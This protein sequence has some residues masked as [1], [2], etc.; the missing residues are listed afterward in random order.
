MLDEHGSLD[1]EKPGLSL[2]EVRTIRNHATQRA[3]N[4]IFG[5]YRSDTYIMTELAKEDGMS[6][7]SRDCWRAYFRNKHENLPLEKQFPLYKAVHETLA[8]IGHQEYEPTYGD[9]PSDKW[10]ELYNEMR[11]RYREKHPSD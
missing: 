1:S 5:T 11:R 9:K 10:R 8:D 3:V 6:K 2:Q 7:Y 4:A